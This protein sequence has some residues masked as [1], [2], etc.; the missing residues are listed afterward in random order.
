MQQHDDMQ[1]HDETGAADR[2]GP[3]TWRK[4]QAIN[5]SGDCVEMAALTCGGV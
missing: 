3:V 2:F 1:Q 5:P 4:S